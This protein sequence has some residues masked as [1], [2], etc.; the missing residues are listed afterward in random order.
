L[1]EDTG[2][3]EQVQFQYPNEGP[4][5]IYALGAPE[6]SPIV[7]VN[8]AN[9]PA[10]LR[11]KRNERNTEIAQSEA[12]STPMT[13]EQLAQAVDD[14]LQSKWQQINIS[15]AEPATDEEYLRRLYLDLVGRIP[16]VGETRQFLEDTS[17]DRRQQLVDKLLQSRN[18]ATHFAGIWRRMLI[19]EGSDLSRFGGFQAFEEWLAD[20]FQKNTPYDQLVRELLLAEGRI[21]ESGPLLFYAALKMNP[22][23]IAAQTSRTFLGTKLECAQC[24]DHPFDATISQ[25]DF[26][27]LAAVFA[28]ISRPRGEMTA[29]SPV[30]Q[31][32][33]ASRGEVMLPDTETIIP[34]QLPFSRE[35]IFD[36]ANG[37]SRRLQFVDWLTSRENEYFAKSTVNRLWSQLFG[38]GLVEPVDD[39]RAPN[40][41]I[42]PE[43]L[44]LLAEQFVL[45]DFDLHWLMRCL[46]STE[47]YGLS[48][49]SKDSSSARTLH[50][51]QMN[52]KP[53]SAE[54]LYD[55]I[56]VVA[57][58]P[59]GKN[60]N[61]Q[62]STL[63][64]IGDSR[65]EA[66]IE[67]FHAPGMQSIDYQAGIPQALTL[68]HGEVVHSATEINRSGVLQSLMAPFFTDEQRLE[69]LFLATLSRLPTAVEKEQALNQ[70]PPGAAPADRNEWLSDVLWALLNSAEFTM[71]H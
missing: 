3:Q 64:R 60:G 52:L 49:R 37:P 70:L 32:H 43:L 17:V 41:A 51:A 66:F 21:S 42:C 53:F 20:H 57:G 6:S 13:S 4:E 54:Q 48:S 27:G 40:A 35:P 67:L 45:A 29:I 38:R 25:K 46:A 22:E 50:F 8:A 2:I 14:L 26:W 58:T 55:C 18:C 63:V 68:M 33:D 61:A 59:M 11:T 39:M 19:P 62:E 16:T 65:R 31:V 24:H 7:P 15:P 44:D 47:A 23:E 36:E 34:P 71:N 5:T 1:L 30:L 69:T 9:E 56:N 28:R 12:T 10:D